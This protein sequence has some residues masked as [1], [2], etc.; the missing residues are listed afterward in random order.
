M[1]PLV[2]TSLLLI[3]TLCFTCG[4]RKTGKL[5]YQKVSKCYENDSLQNFLLF[6][7]SLL[8]ALIVRNNHILAGYFFIFLKNVLNQTWQAFNT[9]FGPQWKDR[10]RSHQ[11][12]QILALVCILVELILDWNCTKALELQKLSRRSNLKGSGSS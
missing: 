8:T 4:D 7:A 9:K 6:F 2:Y 3:T 11:V 10:E 5:N 1:T 12:R